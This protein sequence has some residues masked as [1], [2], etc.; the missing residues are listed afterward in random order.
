MGCLAVLFALNEEEVRALLA[1]ERNGRAAY[2]HEEIEERFF[3]SFPE[4]TCELDK[5]WDAMHRMLTDGNLDFENKFP[6]LCNVIFGGE[7]VYG[8]ARRPSGEVEIPEG[9][10]DEYII[11]KSPEQVA[12]VAKALPRRTKEACWKQYRQIDEQDYGMP[13]DEDD[14]EYTWAYLQDSLAFWQRAADEKRY[15]LFTADR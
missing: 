13:L 5:S 2:M 9:E 8:L 3:D 11:L 15:V 1:V 10:E 4:Y 6:P 14:F 7:F 12:E